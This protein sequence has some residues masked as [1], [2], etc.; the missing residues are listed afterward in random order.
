MSE[1]E[2]EAYLNLLA[3]TLKL[4]EA[5]RQRIA[6]EL[7]DHLEER[8]ADLVDEGMDRDAAILAA[9]D[10]FGDANVLAKDLSE[11]SRRLYRRRLM[12]TSF[13]TLAS[14][15]VLA[16]GFYLF[17]PAQTRTGQPLL[18]SANAQT[19]DNNETAAAS[20]SD[21]STEPLNQVITVGFEQSPLS[22]VFDYFRD[23]LG[24]NVFVQWD[25]LEAVGLER[26]TPITM[27]LEGVRAETALGLL[28]ESLLDANFGEGVGF[29]LRDNV[30]VFGLATRFDR[31]ELVIETYDCN[32]MIEMSI[33]IRNEWVNPAFEQKPEFYPDR[34]LTSMIEDALGESAWVRGETIGIFA[35]VVVVR[36]TP[37]R[38]AQLRE[39]LQDVS[40]RLED[41]TAQIAEANRRAAERERANT[42]TRRGETRGGR[43]SRAS[44]SYGGGYGGGDF[45]GMGYGGEPGFGSDNSEFGGGTYGRGYGDAE[46]G[47]GTYDGTPRD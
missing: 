27:Q 11:P 24:V 9:L 10:E 15:A 28:S 1:R 36:Q 20:S 46:F 16:T 32:R 6:G 33:A 7:R 39:V 41:R 23:V 37:E 14:A 40:V 35:G 34:Y 45:G 47:E 44:S 4:S 30:L 31:H 38:H 26:D 5:Q 19:Q 2:F 13:A 43:S 18:P 42:Q 29:E 22:S 8:M 25:G 21:K 3:R 17:L 12:H